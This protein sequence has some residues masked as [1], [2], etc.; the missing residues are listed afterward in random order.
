MKTA[1]RIHCWLPVWNPLN[2]F[3]SYSWVLD[4]C[5]CY[6]KYP[7]VWRGCHQSRASLLLPHS[8]FPHTNQSNWLSF[9]VTATGALRHRH[10]RCRKIGDFLLLQLTSPNQFTSSP[11]NGARTSMEIRKKLH[12]FAAHVD[13]RCGFLLHKIDRPSVELRYFCWPPANNV[14]LRFH[15]EY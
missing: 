8:C 5:W 1:N 2:S 6:L 13:G 9:G 11:T 15:S 3:A 14:I 4:C 10:C 7:L 12:D